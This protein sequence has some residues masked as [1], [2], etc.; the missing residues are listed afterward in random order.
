MIIENSFT[1]AAPRDAVVAHFLDAERTLRCV[2]GVE[3]VARTGEH[4]YTA[5]LKAKVGP[6]RATFQGSVTYDPA[7]APERVR[8]VGEGRDRASGSVAK[9]ALDATFGEPEPGATLVATR[10][11]VAIRGRF[12]Q[13]G[14]GV[15]QAI[16][17]ELIGEFARCVQAQLAGEET[18]A[19]R[20]VGSP[21]GLA[22]AAARGLVKGSAA[23]L[24][25]LRRRDEEG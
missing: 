20:G 8:A 11:D 3:A 21:S 9:V 1:V 12:G 19:D 15:I 23:R 16:A 5:T 6:I 18:A 2:P 25:G 13:F 10:A 17:D 24:G 14:T 4:A 7:D 22:A